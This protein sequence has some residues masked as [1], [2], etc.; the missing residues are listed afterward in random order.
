M[1]AGIHKLTFDPS[2]ADDTHNVGAY[3][4]A[5]VDGKLVSSTTDNSKE[6]L[7]VTL[8]AEYYEG[9]AHTAGDKGVF[10]LA[11]DPNGNYAPLTVNADGELKV[12]VQVTS[13]SDKAEDSAHVSG[14]IGTYV[15]AVRQDLLATSVDADGDY[16]SLKTDVKGAIWANVYKNAPASNNAFKVT[17]KSVGTTAG[18]ILAADLTNRKTILI[19]NASK[20]QTVA[21]G[22][23]NAVTITGATGGHLIAAGGFL[24]LELEA[25]VAVY[26]ISSASNADLRITEQAYTA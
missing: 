1:S 21:I 6:R 4:R 8:G 9:T 22:E 25:G 13:G 16:T 2:V 10:A 26:A 11:V 15:L 19:Q 14:D 24:E 3:V 12:D 5:G 17:Q 7:D 23:T 20:T 18:V